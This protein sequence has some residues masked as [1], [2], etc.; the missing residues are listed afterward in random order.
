VKIKDLVEILGL[1]LVIPFVGC[2]FAMKEG[3]NYP[4]SVSD[5]GLKRRKESN[6]V[7]GH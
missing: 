3:I 1:L 7:W 2:A 5:K 4:S 6:L